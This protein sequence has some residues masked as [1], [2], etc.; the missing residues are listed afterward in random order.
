MKTARLLQTALLA[1]FLGSVSIGCRATKV[2]DPTTDPQRIKKRVPF[3]P[4][5]DG[6]FLPDATMLRVL[7][8]LSEK[9]VF[10]K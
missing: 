7:D 5:V 6:Y 2:L 3:T 4:P 9:D 1:I 8:H 10:G